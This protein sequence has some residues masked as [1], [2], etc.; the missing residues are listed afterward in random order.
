MRIL[1]FHSA[2]K[3]KEALWDFSISFFVKYQKIERSTLLET[4]LK[5]S[6]ENRPKNKGEIEI[7]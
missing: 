1:K 2:E 3:S 6:G 7:S 5:L 4:F